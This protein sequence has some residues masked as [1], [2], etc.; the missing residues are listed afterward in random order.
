L[1]KTQKANTKEQNFKK[2]I[3]W[4]HMTSNNSFLV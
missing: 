3:T 4:C 2:S 1:A